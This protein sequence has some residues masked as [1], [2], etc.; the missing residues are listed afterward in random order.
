V[1]TGLSIWCWRRVVANI[2]CDSRKQ[3]RRC[4]LNSSYSKLSL[5]TCWFHVVYLASISHLLWIDACTSFSE[6]WIMDFTC[7]SCFCIFNVL[8][9]SYR[10]ADKSLARPG[11]KQAT[12]TKYFDFHT[13]IYNHN[14]RN[15]STIYIYNKA[16]IKRHI[17]TIK[18]NTSGSRSE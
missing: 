8:C 17:L 12:A 4:L 2:G 7:I 1:W 15:I 16:S 6:F 10:G 18:Q 11:R 3:R 9:C 5:A 13:P 14:W